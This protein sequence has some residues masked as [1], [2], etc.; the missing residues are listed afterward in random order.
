MELTNFNISNKKIS[1][2]DHYYANLENLL[3]SNFN[4]P[5]TLNSYLDD[6][7]PVL[8]LNNNELDSYIKNTFGNY[9]DKEGLM[10][11]NVKG[12]WFTFFC[13]DDLQSYIHIETKI[14]YLENTILTNEAII[15]MP[16]DEF[17]DVLRQW[18]TIIEK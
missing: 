12:R 18:K 16:L 11:Y 3:N 5:N 13:Y 14:F 7:S 1:F 6:I 9:W 8:R 10:A 17:V 4:K 2:N 15:E